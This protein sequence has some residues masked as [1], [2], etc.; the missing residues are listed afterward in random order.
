MKMLWIS[1]KTFYLYLEWLFFCFFFLLAHRWRSSPTSWTTRCVTSARGRGAEASSHL[2]SVPTSHAC[3]T[4]ASIAGPASTRVP[5]ASSTSPWS[6][7]EATGPAT[8]PS[9]GADGWGGVI[10]DRPAPP[11]PRSPA[12]CPHHPTCPC[13]SP[14][15]PFPP[16]SNPLTHSLSTLF[17]STDHLFITTKSATTNTWVFLKSLNLIFFFPF[18]FGYIF[19]KEILQFQCS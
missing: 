13:K 7:K 2:S 9:A 16:A 10:R 6:R 14:P 19:F 12:R 15:P 11:L 17:A 1:F 5:A 18:F 4:T 3:S 8:C